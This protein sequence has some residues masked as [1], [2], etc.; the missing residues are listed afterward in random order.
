M[1][2]VFFILFMVSKSKVCYIA[3]LIFLDLSISLA[4]WDFVSWIGEKPKDVSQIYWFS[5]WRYVNEYVQNEFLSICI[6]NGFI[7]IFDLYVFI[8]DF[9]G[10]LRCTFSTIM[11]TWR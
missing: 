7:L 2:I 9:I 1:T 10:I 3:L 6:S 11:N 4:V 5:D 8:R